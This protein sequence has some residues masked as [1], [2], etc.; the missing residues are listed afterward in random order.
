MHS[1]FWCTG[2]WTLTAR[3]CSELCGLQQQMLMKMV[4]SRPYRQET[5]GDFMARIN[6]KVARLKNLHHVV[7]WDKHYHKLVFSWAGHL[8]RMPTY[9]AH[10]ETYKVFCFKDWRW[11]QGV[12]E[13]NAGNQLHC[14]RL[15]VW[16][17][18]RP[19]VKYFEDGQDGSTW[20]AKA[21]DKESWT[22]QLEVMAEWRC[23]V[24]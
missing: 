24:Q 18:E 21:Q 1:L 19:M 13:E 9:A 22:S 15:R 6:R 3:K 8:T 14:R 2:S 12:A 5:K 23:R 17:W 7:D 11:I 10:R 16:R 20:Q 4:D